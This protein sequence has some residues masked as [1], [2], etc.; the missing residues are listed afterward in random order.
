MKL[1][2]K[3]INKK[4]SPLRILGA[5]SLVTGLLDM[6]EERQEITILPLSHCIHPLNCQFI[7]S[8]VMRD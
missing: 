2:Y 6:I 4:V 7:R 5:E 1:L 8:C 3:T